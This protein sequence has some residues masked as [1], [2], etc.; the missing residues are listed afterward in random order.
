M[1]SDE[2]EE[3]LVE[4]G[5]EAVAIVRNN[6]EKEL[7]V[8]VRITP[9]QVRALAEALKTNTVL[10]TLDLYSLCLMGM[11]CGTSCLF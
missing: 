2:E 3:M 7:S 5:D 10:T 11:L 6:E 1:S 9:Q 8:H 4:S